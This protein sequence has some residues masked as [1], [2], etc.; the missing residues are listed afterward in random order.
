MGVC[1]CGR[2][3]QSVEQAGL[4]VYRAV[5]VGIIA[6]RRKVELE[7]FAECEA[8]E[9]QGDEHD[10]P[11]QSWGHVALFGSTKQESVNVRRKGYF[12]PLGRVQGLIHSSKSRAGELGGGSIEKRVK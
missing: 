2:E 1:A 3:R 6:T 10:V 5:A 11:C 4:R 7:L 12:V 8:Q 9:Q